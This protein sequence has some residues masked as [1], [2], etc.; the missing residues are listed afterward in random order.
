MGYAHSELKGVFHL[1]FDDFIDLS[2]ASLGRLQLDTDPYESPLPSSHRSTLR[3]DSH[4]LAE[5]SE[6]DSS[7]TNQESV[8][9]CII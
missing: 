1:D 4:I 8:R 5:I 6:M 7:F 2:S 9:K 3:R